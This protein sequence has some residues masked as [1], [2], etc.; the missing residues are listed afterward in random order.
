MSLFHKINV[1]RRTYRHV[2]RYRQILGVLI[3]YGFDDLISQLHFPKFFFPFRSRPEKEVARLSR[4]ERLRLV[5]E[6]LGPTFIK[7]GQLLSIRPDLV[8]PALVEELSKLQDQAP[9]FS[10]TEA[11][12]IIEREL[13]APLEEIFAHF[14]QTPIAAASLGQVHRAFLKDGTAVAV[15]VQRPHIEK[16]IEVDLEIMLY[17]ARF[18]QRRLREVRPYNPVGI[19]QE[20]AKYIAKEMDYLLEATNIERFGKNFKNEPDIY[21]PKVYRLYCT[22]RVLVMEY[23]EGIK[24]SEIEKLKAAGYDLR[25]IAKR[26]ARLILR[27]IFEYGFFHGDPHPGNVFILP[28]A[29]FCFLDYGMMGRI[30]EET[31][32]TLAFLL[33]SFVEQDVDATARWL[34]KLCPAEEINLRELKVDLW[35][36]MD[37]Y[38]DVPLRQIELKRLYQQILYL[39]GKHHL[40]IPQDLF[41]LDKTLVIMEGIGLKLDPDFHAVEEI[42]PFVRNLIAK[43]YSPKMV[44]RRWQKHWG[45]IFACLETFPTEAKELFTL[46]K[47]GKIKLEIQ[48]QD[49]E[50]IIDKQS[51]I[52]NRLVLAIIAAALMVS[53]ALIILAGLPPFLLGIPSLGLI[54]LVSAFVLILGLLIAVFSSKK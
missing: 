46:L 49:L 25:L 19:V 26:G 18:L 7:L 10:F 1:I 38:Y 47:K 37:Q 13:K 44:L 28:K 31:K 17:F 35:E 36:I 45:E 27:Q 6:E 2:N 15:K 29:I 4:Y 32:E 9:P 34:L 43:R 54:G 30:D 21:V 40:R 39:V 52:G 48:H 53:S 41:L 12:E 14:E 50:K 23:V 11:K 20:F 51:Q 33:R 3:K 42:K 24:I 16:T 22:K 8:P 5:L